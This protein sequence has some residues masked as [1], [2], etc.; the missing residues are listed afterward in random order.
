MHDEALEDARRELAQGAKR[1]E[2]QGGESIRCEGI[3]FFHVE[4]D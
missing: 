3:V 4:L 2:N 1:V